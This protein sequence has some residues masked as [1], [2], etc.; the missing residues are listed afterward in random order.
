MGEPNGELR[1]LI[2]LTGE[3]NLA[4]VG[5]DDVSDHG[6]SEPGAASEVLGAEKGLKNPIAGLFIH[7][8]PVV[9]DAQPNASGLGVLGRYCDVDVVATMPDGVIEQVGQ[10]LPQGVGIGLDFGDCS[11]LG[12]LLLTQADRRD[13]PDGSAQQV[14]FL[15]PETLAPLFS[16]PATSFVHERLPGDAPLS[17]CDL[18]FLAAETRLPRHKVETVIDEL[19]RET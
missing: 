5:L 6:E 14:T 11:P 2:G 16:N 19:R 8:G 15:H 9:F 13:A 3:A 10:D 1:P 18:E 4:L 7:P 12:V 17:E